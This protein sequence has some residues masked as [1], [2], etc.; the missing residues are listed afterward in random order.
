MPEAQAKEQSDH[1]GS[2]IEC[3]RLVTLGILAI[4][5]LVSW[6]LLYRFIGY[7]K[8]LHLWTLVG[9]GLTLLLSGPTIYSLIDNFLALVEG[10]AT[11]TIIV[12]LCFTSIN[13]EATIVSQV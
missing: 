3:R 6:V 9:L 4:M 5:L 2:A 10:P 11:G 8:P 13:L 7:G 1:R 12:F